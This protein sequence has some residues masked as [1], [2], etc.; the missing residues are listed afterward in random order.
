MYSQGTMKGDWLILNLGL[1]LKQ[2]FKK[3]VSKFVIY[4]G[5]YFLCTCSTNTAYAFQTISMSLK[6]LYKENI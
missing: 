5:A 6:R 2:D 3:G 4:L 1:G